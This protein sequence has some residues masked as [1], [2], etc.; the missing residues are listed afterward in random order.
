[1]EIT[2]IFDGAKFAQ[3]GYVVNDIEKT[4]AAYAAILGVENPPICTGGEYEITQAKVFGKPAP[5]ADCK[6]AF[7]NLPGGVQFELIEPNDAPS[8]WRDHLNKYGEGIHHIAFTVDNGD[9]VV[10]KCLALGM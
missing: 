8:V 10:E 9:E 1:M 2:K 5:E 6:M 4:K 7:F 3:V